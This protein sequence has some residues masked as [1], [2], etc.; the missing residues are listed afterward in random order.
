M[1]TFTIICQ[2]GAPIPIQF[3]ERIV[4]HYGPMAAI[5]VYAAWILTPLVK[6][7]FVAHTGLV[8][9][10]TAEMP[11]Q[12]K[13]WEDTARAVEAA[14]VLQEDHVATNQDVAT[15]LSGIHTKLDDIRKRG[16]YRE[17]RSGD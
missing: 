15:S 14:T 3:W 10:L 11:K 9:T 7:A 2:T 8:E 16:G 12:T 5:F 17:P 4:F 13:A 1:T 6:K